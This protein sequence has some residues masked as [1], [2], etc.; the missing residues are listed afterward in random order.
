M[1]DDEG[2]SSVTSFKEE[3]DGF[4]SLL[5]LLQAQPQRR[6]PLHGLFQRRHQ[7]IDILSSMGRRREVL[8]QVLDYIPASQNPDEVPEIDWF[9]C[10]K[11][12]LKLCL[13][14]VEFLRSL[15]GAVE[16]MVSLRD[17]AFTVIEQDPT[18]GHFSVVSGLLVLI[19]ELLA[20][21]PWSNFSKKI[22]KRVKED[23][24]V[25]LTSFK[26]LMTR[27]E[28]IEDTCRDLVNK[29]QQ[30]FYKGPAYVPELPSR[31]SG[32]AELDHGLCLF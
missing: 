22:E 12:L 24:D 15:N 29:C 16:N 17:Q 1:E 25:V 18:T 26:K 19:I 27:M 31:D 14:S 23:I 9:D 11:P 28:R 2:S 30:V 13:S 7:N 20:Q 8:Q 21:I 6:F 3:C 5:E 32:F 10:S 4:E